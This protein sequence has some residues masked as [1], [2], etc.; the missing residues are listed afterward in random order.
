MI[1][2]KVGFIVFGVHKDNLLDPMG[3]PFIDDKVIK[4]AKKTLRDA[5]LDLVEN[6]LIIASK[7]EARECLSRYILRYLGLGCPSHCFFTRFFI[8]R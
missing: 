8:I 4:Q 7:K 2:P 1:K 3:T 5:G 6:D